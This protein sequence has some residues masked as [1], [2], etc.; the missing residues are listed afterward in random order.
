LRSGRRCRLRRYDR[1]TVGWC[2]ARERRSERE[3]RRLAELFER[4][5]IIAEAWGLKERFRDVYRADDRVEAQRRL[6]AFLAAVA[7]AGLP[8]FEAVAKGIRLWR[9]ELLSY[10]D[11]PTTTATP[12]A[13]STRSSSAAPT[14]SPPSPP[15]ASECSQHAAEGDHRG[16]SASCPR[17]VWR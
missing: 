11:E 10:F 5:P 15:S 2:E 3:R 17:S 4:D 12:K 6:E 16:L 8:A 13:S 9:D 14:A 1:P 7:R